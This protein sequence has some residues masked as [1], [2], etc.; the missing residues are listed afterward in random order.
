MKAQS[1]LLAIVKRV[2]LYFVIFESKIGFKTK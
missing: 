2:D 1:K